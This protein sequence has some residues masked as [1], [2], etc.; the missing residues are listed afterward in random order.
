MKKFPALLAINFSLLATISF[1][2]LTA[3]DLPST[4]NSL[5]GT[6]TII[7]SQSKNIQLL[8]R[9]Q[10]KSTAIESTADIYTPDLLKT[11]TAN[12]GGMITGRL[13]GVYTGQTSGKPG[14]DDVSLYVRG[15]VPLVLIDGTPQSFSSIN[16]E[17][18]ESIT[19]LKDALSTAMLGLRSANGAILI[20]T[21][22]GTT[23]KTNFSFSARQGI[24]QPLGMPKYLNA[25]DYANLYNEARLNDGYSP[26]YSQADLDAY[27]NGTDSFGHPNVDW[28]DVAFRDRSVFSRYDM[29]VS[30]G[31]TGFRYFVNLDYLHQEGMFKTNPSNV[32]NSN[33]DYKRYILRSNVDIDISKS[34]TAMVNISGRL[35]D[36]NQ[37]G[38]GADVIFSNIQ[39]TPN[40][41]YPVFN[42]DGS[43]AGNL[44]FQN[45]IYSQVFGS[46]YRVSNGRD[47]KIDASLK[48][49]MDELV[50]GMWMK[51]LVAL[52]SYNLEDINRSRT[53]AVF[54]D[55]SGGMGTS[56]KQ[57]GTIGDQ[58]N[59]SAI[60]TQNRLSYSELSLG[61]NTK[62][63][64]HQLDALVLANSDNNFTNSDLAIRY[65]GLSGNLSYAYDGKYMLQA[66]GSYSGSNHYPAGNRAGFFPAFG[67]G[68]VASNEAFLQN[69]KW[70]SL[71]KFRASYGINANDAA[72]YFDY[73]QNYVAGDGYNFGNA[74]TAVTGLSRDGVA[75]ENQRWEKAKK[76]NIGL[77]AGLFNDRLTA[78]VDYFNNEFYDLLQPR[79][80]AS[81]I[82]GIGY[83][84]ENIGR[85]RYTGFELQLSYKNTLHRFGY[86]VSPNLTMMRTKVIYQDEPS[87]PFS[88]MSR[89][90]QPIGQLFGYLAEGLF[91]TQAE[92]D[93]SAKPFPGVQPGDIKYKDLN[94]DGIINGFDQTAIGSTKPQVYYGV[95]MGINWNGF[96]LSALIQGVTNRNLLVTGAGFW[97]FQNSGRGQA[98]AHNLDRWTPATAATATYPRVSVG[99][100]LN[101]SQTSSFW[102]RSGNYLRL[103]SVELGYS[104]PGGLISRLK[105]EEARLFLNGYNLLTASSFD[106]G[107]PEAYNAGYPIQ[108]MLNAGLTIKF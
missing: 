88:W 38:A 33:S 11:I 23:G 15:R 47:F 4:S 8:Y 7:T 28:Q 63:G 107:D 32:N 75:N 44:N 12:Y 64:R 26:A 96:D 84:N 78:T 49:K 17:Q 93:A 92:A 18:I 2:S 1:Q 58:S 59:T 5:P 34:L 71:L 67:I 27:K 73:V 21:K 30:G 31:G 90:G 24:Q 87:L 35:Q 81:G 105:I 66:A 108:K 86:F 36:F 104:L 102:I 39:A 83:P 89:T 54:Q 45:N 41:A 50:K 52:R 22:K 10:K 106:F 94:G 53:V 69:K 80:D 74:S 51:G 98:Y 103:K 97:E 48:L 20:T 68:W 9:T 65:L 100:N 25:F 43:L 16:P 19:V 6:D 61:Y 62:K 40:S 70:L 13:A 82:S 76:I 101:N 95:D 42:R 37:P 29:A 77:D 55:M 60:N 46:G 3:Q 91:Q 79:G 99:T 85:N 56:Y 57:F 14:Y 72:G